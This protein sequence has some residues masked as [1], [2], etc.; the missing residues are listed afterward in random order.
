MNVSNRTFIVFCILVVAGA[1][2]VRAQILQKGNKPALV[3][4]PATQVV[5]KTEVQHRSIPDSA[6]PALPPLDATSDPQ[7]GDDGP[8]TVDAQAPAKQPDKQPAVNDPNANNDDDLIYQ[9]D[10]GDDTQTPPANNNNGM[11]I[12]DRVM[13]QMML[14]EMTPQ[15]E[16]SFRMMWFTMT[17]DDRQDFLDQLRGQDQGG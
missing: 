7:A 16:Q 5:A 17:P 9:D 6:M 12:P 15:Q 3:E 2:F 14:N 10:I 13:L 11:Q 8:V 1:A 4:A